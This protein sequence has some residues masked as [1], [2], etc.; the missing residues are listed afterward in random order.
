MQV[1]PDRWALCVLA[2]VLVAAAITDVRLGKIPNLVTLPAIAI[3]LVG[4]TLAGGMAGSPGTM[5]LTDSLA[6]LAM[7]FV[8]MLLAWKA[9]GIGGGDAKLMAAVGALSG[10]EFTLSSMFYGLAVA[11]IMA[12]AVML[13]RRVLRRTLARV[14]RFLF[15]V[16]ARTRPGDPATAESPKVPFGLALCIGSAAAAVQFAVTGRMPRVF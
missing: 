4:H 3:G 5:G 2:A 15:L 9:G 10:W 12:I 7:G 11:A 6:G 14:G 16:L 1:A 13:R 8:P